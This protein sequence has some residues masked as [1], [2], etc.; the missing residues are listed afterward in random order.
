M[1][2][3]NLSSVSVAAN[4]T[5]FR[6]AGEREHRTVRISASRSVDEVKE[7]DVEDLGGKSNKSASVYISPLC[8]TAALVY[9]RDVEDDGHILDMHRP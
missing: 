4:A 7:S 8:S 6:A 9:A 1:V 5:V 2:R 3:T